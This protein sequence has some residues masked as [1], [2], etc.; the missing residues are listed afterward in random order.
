MKLSRAV[1]FVCAVT[2]QA[3]LS[4]ENEVIVTRD[5]GVL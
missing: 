4:L 5:L 2:V 3:V 1:L